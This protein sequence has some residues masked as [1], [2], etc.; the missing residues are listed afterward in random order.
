[1]PERDRARLSGGSLQERGAQG[2]TWRGAQ[3]QGEGTGPPKSEPTAAQ[4]ARAEGRPRSGGRRPRQAGL[5][6]RPQ[7][8]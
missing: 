5:Q 7:A 3:G 2:R 1:M 4:R 6:R 8:S